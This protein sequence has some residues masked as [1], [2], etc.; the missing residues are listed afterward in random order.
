VR[1]QDRRDGARLPAAR[2]GRPQNP[3][4]VGAGERVEVDRRN[5]ERVTI[6]ESAQS[7]KYRDAPLADER[8]LQRSR[9]KQRQGGEDR[10]AAIFT[11]LVRI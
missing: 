1:R 5:V 3:Q 11:G 9:R 4:A 8:Q 2:A 10:V 6:I 7:R